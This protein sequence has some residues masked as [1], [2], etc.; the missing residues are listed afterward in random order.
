[1]NAFIINLENKPGELARL[2][3][4]LAAR[5]I[6]IESIAGT[7]WGSAGAIAILTNDEA[8]SR[9]ALTGGSFMIREVEIVP[10]SMEHR[11]GAL[12]EIARKLATAG[13]NIEAV[14][15]TGMAGGKVS[16]AL[17]TSD[18]VMAR[19]AIGQEALATA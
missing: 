3:E 17:A 4:T 11:P 16:V 13:V 6:N 8:G 7:T 15:P 5:G 19:E 14:L 12:A 1:L 18:P 2:T 10:C 9:A